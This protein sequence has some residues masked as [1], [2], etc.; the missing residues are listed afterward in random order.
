MDTSKKEQAIQIITSQI[1]KISAN[2][3]MDYGTVGAL[4]GETKR[5]SAAFNM[6]RL[7]V[8]R[9]GGQFTGTLPENYSDEERESV[10]VA[11]EIAAAAIAITGK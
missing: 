3:P 6:A 9:M 2:T 8:T 1:S 4:R 10:K 7:V 11:K 5:E